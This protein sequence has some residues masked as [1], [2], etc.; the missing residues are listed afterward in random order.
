EI[1]LTGKDLPPGVTLPPQTVP[2]GQSV[3]ALV[4]AADATAKPWTGPVRVLATATIN[5]TKV[6]REVRS[7]TISW[8]VPTPN[9][10]TITRL[11]RELV[12]AVRDRPPF[13]LTTGVPEITVAMGQPITVPLKLK[14][15]APDFKT[16]VQ[17]VGLNLPDSLIAQPVT[18]APGK[19]EAKV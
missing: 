3:G 12:L 13:T 5:G 11:D 1:I 17:V 2:A 10:P 18:L 4:L 14:R 15:L 6:V 19:D 9:I 16:P 8:P 7:A